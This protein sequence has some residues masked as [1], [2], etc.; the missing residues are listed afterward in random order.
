MQATLRRLE[1]AI[2]ELHEEL[3]QALYAD[4]GKS[5]LETLTTETSVVLS[6]IQ[7]LRR[8]GASLRKPRRVRTPLAHWPA[9]SVIWSEPWGKVLVLAPWNFPFQ[10]ALVPALSAWAAGN[11][12]VLKPSERTPATSALIAKLVAE[13]FTPAEF[14]V[15]TGDAEVAASLLAKP[16]DFVFFTG[17]REIGR[18]VGLSA[19]ER[20]IPCVLELGGKSPAVILEGAD[21]ELAARRLLWGKTVNAG[22]TCVAPDYVLVPS[23]LQEVFVDAFRRALRD[24]FPQGPLASPDLA[25]II[26]RQAWERLEA[27]ARSGT[28]ACGGEKDRERLLLGPTLLTDVTWNDPLMA[29]EIFGPLLPVLT[30]TSLEDAKQHISLARDPLA[31]YVFGPPRQAE[32][33]FLS[34]PAGGG[35]VNDVLLHFANTNLPFGG[36]GSSGWGQYHGAAGWRTFRREKSLV[37]RPSWGDWP[38]RYPPY[39]T[40]KFKLLKRILGS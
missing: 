1:K 32:A 36:R 20:H 10:L 3:A 39:T 8:K 30:Y 12:V 11:Q 35:C 27:L 2:R 23:Q 38:F 34:V 7:Y 16:W 17:S 18:R 6:E 28:I 22:Q 29:G 21:V 24:F 15:V 14:T 40:G 26:H 13:H 9:R 31:L 5:S 37:L 25:R 4:F 33:F 19:S